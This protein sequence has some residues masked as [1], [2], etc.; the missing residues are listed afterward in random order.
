MNV[1]YGLCGLMLIVAALFQAN[2]ALLAQD[3]AAAVRANHANHTNAASSVK[4]DN[5]AER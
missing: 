1:R 5:E 2:R 4:L 3:V